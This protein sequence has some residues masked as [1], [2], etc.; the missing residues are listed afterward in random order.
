MYLIVHGMKFIFRSQSLDMIESELHGLIDSE[1]AETHPFF[2]LPFWT[3][4]GC[5]QHTEVFID[6]QLSKEGLG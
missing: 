2:E 1:S 5:L 4:I 6:V 3:N